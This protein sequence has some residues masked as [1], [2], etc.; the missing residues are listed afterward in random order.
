MAARPVSTMDQEEPKEIRIQSALSVLRDPA[1]ELSRHQVATKYGI[2][3]ATL[4]DRLNGK[5]P[6]TDVNKTKQL[7]T[8]EQ[9]HTLEEYIVDMAKMNI[10]T[11]PQEAREMAAKIIRKNDPIAPVPSETWFRS[12]IKRSK[13]LSH[14][15]RGIICVADM[16]Q[17]NKEMSPGFDENEQDSVVELDRALNALKCGNITEV[18][19]RICET[20]LLEKDSEYLAREIKR[21]L[22]YRSKDWEKKRRLEA[23]LVALNQKVKKLQEVISEL[24]EIGDTRKRKRPELSGVSSSR[25]N[26]GGD[27]D[28]GDDA[29]ANDQSQRLELQLQHMNQS[30]NRITQIREI[31]SSQNISQVEETHTLRSSGPFDPH[32]PTVSLQRPVATF[33]SIN[34]QQMPSTD[35]MVSIGSIA[36]IHPLSQM[37]ELNQI[38]DL[39]QFTQV[40]SMNT[41]M[42]PS[43]TQAYQMDREGPADSYMK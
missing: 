32:S 18:D 27:D 25:G 41:G 38:T 30:Q 33:G 11:T 7:L 16:E 6:R 36:S 9:E 14:S 40:M 28:D 24:N 19:W 23:E 22:E 26:S 2:P 29:V 15:K 42:Q 37:P 31:N 21:Q 1:N 35:R 34:M 8:P 43:P 10:S 4:T 3:Y 20:H 39:A 5:L 13:R 12:F 17:S